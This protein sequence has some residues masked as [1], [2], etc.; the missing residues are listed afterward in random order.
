MAPQICLGV[1]KCGVAVQI[2]AKESHAVLT[3]CYGHGLK[4]AE[5]DTIKSLNCVLYTVFEISK[6]IRFSP[7]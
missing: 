2:Q 7:K 3:H 6:L 5:G 1:A 4:L